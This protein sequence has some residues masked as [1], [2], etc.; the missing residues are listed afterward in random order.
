MITMPI[1]ASARPA[2]NSLT[3][4]VTVK[5]SGEVEP[6]SL[7]RV[8]FSPSTVAPDVV[9]VV[10]LSPVQGTVV[11]VGHDSLVHGAA[12][13]VVVCGTVVVVV[14]LGP[15]H[16]A[17]VVVVWGTVVVVSWQP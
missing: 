16:G 5:D 9:V 6:G 4:K 2:K 1:R 15:V 10:Q 13:V 17:V 14:Q 7:G 11:V 12:V 8:K 3:T